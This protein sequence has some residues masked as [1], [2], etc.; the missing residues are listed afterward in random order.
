MPALL[1]LFY[2]Y[3]HGENYGFALYDESN[4]STHFKIREETYEIENRI[5]DLQHSSKN[6]F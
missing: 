3:F 1:R 4:L 6:G 5:S 2:Y